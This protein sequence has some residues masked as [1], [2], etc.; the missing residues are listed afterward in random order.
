MEG[1][2]LDVDSNNI[3]GYFSSEQID[4]LSIV[5]CSTFKEIYDFISK[6]DQLNGVY[7]EKQLVELSRVD[8]EDVKRKVFKDYQDTMVLH[9]ADKIISI[10]N[11]LRHIG[12][13]DEDFDIIRDALATRDMANIRMIIE[14]RYPEQADKMFSLNHHFVSTERDQTKATDMYDEFVFLN[15]QLSNFNT[16]LVGSG[17]IYSVVNDFYT[18]YEKE[19]RFD[20]YSAK[21]DLDFAQR[22]GKQ[23]RF[24]SLLVKEDAS[25]LFDDKSKEEILSILEE[26]V[27]ASIDFVNE[28]NDTHKVNVNGQEVPV[29]NAIDLFNEI[30]SFDKNEEGEYYNIWESKYGISMQELMSVFEYA[31]IHKPDGVSY[32]YNEPFLE[33]DQ[34]RQKVFETLEIIDSLL[35]GLIDT[36]G[37]QMHITITMPEDK[38]ER[39]FEAFKV[40]QDKTGKKI[41]IT[42]YDMCLGSNEITRVFGQNADVSLEQVYEFKKLKNDMFTKIIKDSGVVLSGVSYWSLTDGIDCNLE[43]IRTNALS[44]GQITDIKQIPT[45]CGG[46]FPTHKTLIEEKQITSQRPLETKKEELELSTFE[47]KKEERQAQQ[48][49]INVM[50]EDKKQIYKQQKQMTEQR[51]QNRQMKNS[52]VR[53]LTKS[54]GSSN[55]FIDIL[56]LT[57]FVVGVLFMV[58]YYIYK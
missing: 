39:C 16:M 42:E 40:L 25:H 23:I 15:S 4:L 14:E 13:K 51:N 38:I 19:K 11:R 3:G 53:M 24:H 37:S 28:Y 50:S 48:Q 52:R 54:S 55:G 29:I 12:V 30:I 49:S 9:D 1:Y 7:A 44:K 8:I 26:Y 22:N 20:F 33:D 56:I 41:Q 45:A 36:L 17:R 27:K 21:R 46:L 43:R 47:K 57:L 6:C 10:D 35:P 32:L 31:K 5:Q 18:S 34:R 2:Y 58:I